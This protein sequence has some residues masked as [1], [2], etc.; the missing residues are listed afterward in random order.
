MVLGTIRPSDRGIQKMLWWCF[1]KV[2]DTPSAVLLHG[3]QSL[4][5]LLHWYSV[6]IPLAHGALQGLSALLAK[7]QRGR[8]RTQRVHLDGAS[9]KDLEFWRWLLDVGLQKPHVWSTPLWF[10]AGELDE[11]EV[12]RLYTDARV[13]AHFSSQ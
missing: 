10:L 13:C 3:L 11:R 1:R 4:V 2:T 6:V 9:R 7:A 8:Q 5:S 12:A